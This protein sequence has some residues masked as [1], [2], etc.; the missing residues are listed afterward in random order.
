MF[1]VNLLPRNR[2]G[3]GGSRQ[4]VS[5]DNDNIRDFAIIVT[6]KQPIK[7]KSIH[8]SVQV[9]VDGRYI[10]GEFDKSS[11]GSVL[12]WKFCEMT[13]HKGRKRMVGKLQFGR[14]VR[15]C[16]SVR[17]CFWTDIIGDYKCCE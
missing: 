9:W 12:E 7:D 2:G 5:S 16:S 13:F 4:R 17:S 10:V 8:W 11:T 3:T 15:H 6:I 14:L 1:K